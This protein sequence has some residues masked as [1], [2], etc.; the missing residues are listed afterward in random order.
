MMVLIYGFIRGVA[1]ALRKLAEMRHKR[2]QRVYERHEEDFTQLDGDRKLEEVGSG[3]PVGYALQYKLLKSYEAKE[4][5]RQK[6]VAAAN[7]LTNRQSAEA[8]IKRFSGLKLPYSFGL[9]DMAVVMKA[10]DELSSFG[11]TAV[12]AWCK[13]AML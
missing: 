12:I 2:V 6:W 5:A 13:T 8:K 9:L 11:L 10:L 4:Q 1:Y 7:R 3:Q